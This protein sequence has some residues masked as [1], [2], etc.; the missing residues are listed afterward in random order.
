[1]A[2]EKQKPLQHFSGLLI[3]FL[4]PLCSTFI[5]PF[6]HFLNLFTL[7]FSARFLEV[8]QFCKDRF[9][10]LQHEGFFFNLL[11]V[12]NFF[13]C[14]ISTLAVRIVLVI[15]KVILFCTIDLC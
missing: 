10:S 14:V 7:F 4:A 6:C 13:K 8:I 5:H 9:S 15:L 3:D 1:M 2:S 12:F 11:F